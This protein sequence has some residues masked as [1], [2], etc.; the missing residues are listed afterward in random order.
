MIRFRFGL[1]VAAF[2]TML[3]ANAWAQMVKDKP[4][5]GLADG[6]R[7]NQAEASALRA[8]GAEL[9][10]VD[11]CKGALEPLRS[12]WA[13]QKDARTAVLLG[14]CKLKLGQDAEAAHYLALARDLL[15][16]GAE[17]TRV[18][19][20]LQDVSSRVARLD[21]VVNDPDAIVLAGKL[22]VDTPV[23][24][25][26]VPPGDIEVIV[27]KSGFGEQQQKVRAIAGKTERLQFTLTR[28]PNESELDRPEKASGS[29]SM[30]PA[31]VG[32][33]AALASIGIGIG[34]RAAGTNRGDEADALLDKLLGIAPCKEDPAP[35]ECSTILN[36]RLEHDRYVNA[37]T[38]VF[39]T[40]GL[41]LGGAFIY[42][43]VASRK[44]ANDVAIIPVVSPTDHGLF[45]QGRF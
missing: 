38:G 43:M 9:A 40:G 8:E 21:I 22:V 23:E 34:L 35:K 32:A 39:V 44:T 29:L 15:P 24:H 19:S 33:G 3:E 37:S 14:E 27:K 13:L 30:I 42:G 16:N 45:I 7:T 31:Y 18:E 5:A 26:Y 2:V 25:L 41:P 36:L 11:D 12:S 6:P 20:M 17:R 28:R 4:N 1:V 10:R